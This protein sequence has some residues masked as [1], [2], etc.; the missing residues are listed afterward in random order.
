MNFL[1]I[2]FKILS[3]ISIIAIITGVVLAVATSE[4]F[5]VGLLLIALGIFGYAIFNVPKFFAES[6]IKWTVLGLILAA[7]FIACIFLV[8]GFATIIS[9]LSLA[10]EN[11]GIPIYALPFI[12]LCIV[13]LF[14]L[15]LH[16][17]YSL[18]EK[19]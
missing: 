14:L 17:Y 13:F 2:A 15:I 5:V 18:K 10:I 7:I 4:Y 11:L 12:A 8:P 1:K 16:I 19:L 6:Y 3:V 9:N